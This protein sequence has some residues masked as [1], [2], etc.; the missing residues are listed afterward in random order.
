MKKRIVCFL[1]LLVF[2]FTFFHINYKINSE[3]LIDNDIINKINYCFFEKSGNLPDEFEQIYDFDGNASYCLAYNED[4]YLLYDLFIDDFVIVGNGKC[5]FS[6]I[7]GYKKIYSAPLG[8]YYEKEP[9]IIVSIYNNKILTNEELNIKHNL[10]YETR[11]YILNKKQNNKSGMMRDSTA[12][13]ISNDYYFEHL[14][15]NLPV[16]HNGSCCFVASSMLLG[17]YDSLYND[18]FVIDSHEVK[19]Y[20]INIDPDSLSL[21][22]YYESPGTN[23]LLHDYLISKSLYS[24]PLVN[25]LSQG[26]GYTI[27][28]ACMLVMDYLSEKNITT[29]AMYYTEEF[30][31]IPYYIE[32]G[33]NYDRP[34]LAGF[35]GDNIPIHPD[36]IYEHMDHACIAYGYDENSIVVHCGWLPSTD[37]DDDY[38]SQIY[39]NKSYFCACF[40]L[41]YSDNSQGSDNYQWSYN[42]CSGYIKMP[43]IICC[44]HN[45]MHYYHGGNNIYHY[46]NCNACSYSIQQNHDFYIDGFYRICSDCGYYVNICQHNLSYNGTYNNIFHYMDCSICNETVSVEHNFTQSHGIYRCTVCGYQTQYIFDH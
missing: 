19:E 1:V 26:Y 46:Y 34:V 17:Y 9:G 37:E 36:E 10:F 14:Y 8:F 24:L 40:Y 2:A 28:F 5:L 29:T 25:Y 12:T 31:N 38:Y 16:N 23:D 3:S 6:N 43:H 7:E 41:T 32:Q 45:A 15:H 13:F 27:Y 18:N 21:S 35:K 22:D 44:D 11:Q 42:G 39:L 4:N 30:Y 20:S 33:I